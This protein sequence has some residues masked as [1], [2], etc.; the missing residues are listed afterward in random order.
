MTLLF[1]IL[2]VPKIFYISPSKKQ[3]QKTTH[4]KQRNF[5]TCFNIFPMKSLSGLKIHLLKAQTCNIFQFLCKN[6]QTDRREDGNLKVDVEQ[7]VRTL[8][9]WHWTWSSEP[10]DGASHAHRASP[11]SGPACL[12]PAS[13]SAVTAWD[14][15]YWHEPNLGPDLRVTLPQGLT[16]GS[17]KT[18]NRIWWHCC[19]CEV[20]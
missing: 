12:R 8:G 4:R 6:N 11:P 16:P 2:W 17:S 18:K 5:L 1:K 15:D 19:H 13:R 14:P 10:R 20:P 9:G 3:K 7:D